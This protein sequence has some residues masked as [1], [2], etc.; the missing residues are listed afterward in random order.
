MTK[1]D[2]SCH[3]SGRPSLGASV[4]PILSFGKDP[5]SG[6]SSPTAGSSSP[7]ELCLQAQKAGRP[8]KW[9]P[10]LRMHL[11]SLSSGTKSPTLLP[12]SQYFPCSFFY[13]WWSSN[14]SSCPWNPYKFQ[15]QLISGFSKVIRLYPWIS[16]P[17]SSVLTSISC[18][19][20]FHQSS[21]CTLCSPKPA[22]GHRHLIGMQQKFLVLSPFAKQ[23][24]KTSKIPNYFSLEEYIFQPLSCCAK[25]IHFQT[26][27]RTKTHKLNFSQQWNSS[28]L[29]NIFESY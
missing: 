6:S 24:S 13:W 25:I 23:F 15:L 9:A 21:A 11:L 5:R 22:L 14:S 19:S 7:P 12:A 26:S 18:V 17:L 27:L 10:E 29:M 3:D 1:S 2:G 16:L 28:V 20:A 4:P 8:W